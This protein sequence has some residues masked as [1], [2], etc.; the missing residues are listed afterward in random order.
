LGYAL[1][2][3]ASPALRPFVQELANDAWQVHPLRPVPATLLAEG[4]AQGQVDPGW[5]AEW[6]EK[7]GIS[8]D[9]FRRMVDIA[10]SGP[11]AAAAF[12]LRRRGL[13]D[14][15]G[16][17]RALR[18]EGL[19][20]EWLGPMRQLTQVLLSPAEL[21]NAR[22][23]GFITPDRQHA[24]SADHGIDAERAEVLFELAG[25]PPGA[26][27]AQEAANRGLVDRATFDQMI[28]EG[29]TKTKYTELLWALRRA[30]L[31]PGRGGKR[32]ASHLDHRRRVVRDRGDPRLQPRADGL[33]VPQPWPAGVA[34]PRCGAP[35]L[36]RSTA[37][38][39]SP[40]R[41]RI[42]RRRSR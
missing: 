18:R 27:T 15:A 6:A 33:A 26:A 1:G 36:A 40:R 32:T 5:A 35:G 2:H 23:Q 22:Q 19:E 21:A 31:S 24:E 42:T 34:Q 20:A 30:V 11:G 4:V 29:H 41:S 17:A 39:A 37:R 10:N 38:E 9:A 12:Q 13:I 7:Q 25:L 28:R 3:A 8:G 16:L 14:D